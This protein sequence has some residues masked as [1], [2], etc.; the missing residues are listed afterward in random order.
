MGTRASCFSIHFQ[1]PSSP[2]VPRRVAM[3]GCA[4]RVAFAIVFQLAPAR[5]HSCR[6]LYIPLLSPGS[7]GPGG[8]RNTSCTL[9]LAWAWVALLPL[10][11][12][13]DSG[14][15]ALARRRRA[16][17]SPGGTLRGAR[18]SGRLA[19]GLRAVHSG[20]VGIVPRPEPDGGT[21]PSDGPTTPPVAPAGQPPVAG[22]SGSRRGV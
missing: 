3:I 11:S 6:N 20:P 1:C 7:S 13:T 10:E 12:R 2:R 14:T 22:G 17:S 9:G 16:R 19:G 18:L 21:M 15:P 5:Y 8:W 4:I